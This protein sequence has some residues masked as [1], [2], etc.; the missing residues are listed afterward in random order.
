M[1][2]TRRGLLCLLL[3]V[4]PAGARGQERV[5]PAPLPA[6]DGHIDV[7]LGATKLEAFTYKPADYDAKA[8]PLILVFHGVLRNADTY[9]DSGKPLADRLR[10]LVVAPRFGQQEFSTNRYQFGNLTTGGQPNPPEQW[11]WSL[12]P[13][14]A[15]DIRRREGRPDMPYYLIGHSGGGQFLVRLAGFMST[16]AKRVVAANPGSHL[17]PTRDQPFPYGFGG[18]PESL[19]SDDVIRRYLAQPLTLYLGT[20][21]TVQDEYFPRGAEA[22]KQ[23]ASRYERGKNAFRMGKELAASKGWPFGWQL[24]EAPEVGHDAAKMFAHPRCRQALTGRAD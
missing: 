10:G 13:K 14:L 12:I 22:M 20:G 5:A 11:T 3:L 17:F 16:D 1:I 4:L 9:R 6:G 23:G 19:S 24:V 2:L 15:A 8:G 7:P 18:L 21:D